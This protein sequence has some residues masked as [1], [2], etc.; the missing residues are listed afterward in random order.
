M[1]PRK[2]KAIFRSLIALMCLAATS[3]GTYSMRAS[4]FPGGEAERDPR[5]QVKLLAHAPTGGPDESLGKI[6]PWP[7]AE[8]G[9]S[10]GGVEPVSLVVVGTRDAPALSSTVLFDYPPTD[11]FFEPFVL[12]F[13]HPPAGGPSSGGSDGA[14]PGTPG[15]EAGPDLGDAPITRSGPS[16]FIG[17]PGG[18]SG[19]AG[20]PFTVLSGPRTSDCSDCVGQQPSVLMAVSPV[21]EPSTYAL[22]IAGLLAVGATMRRRRREG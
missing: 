5:A 18:A 10:V 20:S 13:A 17:G 8:R 21:P 6:A 12:A 4:Q 22:M 1:N 14:V 16:A 2:R 9:D 7:T 15:D 11:E 3:I 19:G